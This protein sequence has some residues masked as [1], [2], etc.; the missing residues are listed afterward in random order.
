[1]DYNNG[2]KYSDHRALFI[3]VDEGRLFSAKGQDL[4]TQTGRVLHSKNKLH[5]KNYLT[6]VNKHLAA[7]N[8]VE[9]CS[10]LREMALVKGSEAAKLEVDKIDKEV[11]NAVLHAEKKVANKNYGYGWSPQL[12]LAGRTVT[13]WRNCLCLHRDGFDPA[14][15]APHRQ[16]QEFGLDHQ[17]LGYKLM[18]QNWMIHGLLFVLFKTTPRNCDRSFYQD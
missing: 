13:F 18:N 17:K 8:I 3:D 6:L 11:T 10:R 2:L 1:M 12:A 14:V 7:H 16:C 15:V 5:V 4:F 9:R